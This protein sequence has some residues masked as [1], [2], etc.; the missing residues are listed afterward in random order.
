MVDENQAREIVAYTRVVRRPGFIYYLKGCDVFERRPKQRS[1]EPYV[2]SVKV[3]TAS[4]VREPGYSYFLDRD[5]N[6]ARF[7]RDVTLDD[8]DALRRANPHRAGDPEFESFLDELARDAR[9]RD[10][11]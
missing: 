9:R 1:G 6:I 7:K 8:V 2:P 3:A 4:F 10:D 11:E 5:G